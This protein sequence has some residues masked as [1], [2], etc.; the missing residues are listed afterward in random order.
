MKVRFYLYN[1][2]H[3]TKTRIETEDG[4]VPAVKVKRVQKRLCGI[5]GCTCGNSIGA[6]GDR[7][8][9]VVSCHSDGSVTLFV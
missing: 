3:N 2:F 5:K 9:P 1:D 4:F 7:F 8:N 6:R